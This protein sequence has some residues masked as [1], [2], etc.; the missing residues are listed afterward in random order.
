MREDPAEGQSRSDASRGSLLASLFGPDVITMTA[1]PALVDDALFPHERAYIARA[2]EK[3][4]AEFGTA[5]IC[6]RRALATLGIAPCSLV[7]NADRS[8]HWPPG[9]VGSISHTTGCCAVALTNSV[10]IR[11]LGL[12]VEED[13]PLE[14]RFEAMICTQ[15]ERRWLDHA[16]EAQR[17]R[18]LKLLFSA[19][20]AFYKCQYGVTRTMIGFHDV[21]I[22]FDIASRRFAVAALARDGGEW[23]A[24]RGIRGT[25]VR[26]AGLL[27]TAAVL[28]ARRP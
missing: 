7:P 1:E 15:A 21:T 12:D 9:I 16:G 19:K 18:H 5:R 14:T 2:V 22:D 3:R 27:M 13:S 17:G 10:H 23:D 25:C 6:A 24:V 4:R 26:G 28:D 11:A 20:E 8:P